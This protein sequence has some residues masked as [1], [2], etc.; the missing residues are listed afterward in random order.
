MELSGK[1]EVVINGVDFSIITAQKDKITV[2]INDAEL[3]KKMFKKTGLNIK[4]INRLSK[5]SEYLYKRGVGLDIRDS[6]G[7]FIQLGW[8]AYSPLMKVKISSKRL[9]EFFI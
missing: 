1:V 9:I 3:L 8:G 7:P 2:F 5:V 4:G 6:K